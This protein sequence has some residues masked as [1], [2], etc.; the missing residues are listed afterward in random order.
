[1]R[2]SADQFPQDVVRILYLAGVVGEHNTAFK[3]L[4]CSLVQDESRWVVIPRS[5]SNC[6]MLETRWVK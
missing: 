5:V 1:M 2:R 3:T 4:H 6:S